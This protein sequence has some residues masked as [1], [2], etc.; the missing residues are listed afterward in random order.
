MI[1]PPRLRKTALV[2]HVASSVGWVGAV[3]CFLALAVAGYTATDEWT[4]R[5][6][7]TVMEIIGWTALVPLSALTL[8]TGV[9]QAIGTPWGLLKHYWVL[10]K[11]LI[12]IA[13]TA[14]LLLYMETL[15]VL[16]DAAVQPAPDKTVP[17]ILPDFSPILH[18]AAAL[19]VLL[20]ALGLSIC[21]PRGLTGIGVS[22]FRSAS[23][24]R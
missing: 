10:I 6:A 7:Y 18:S 9:I 23:Q 3:T 4:M 24:R 15:S 19:I 22:M 1:M 14:V 8:V 5:A 12:T 17:D 16:A 2:A 11:L 13:A 20:V 21:K